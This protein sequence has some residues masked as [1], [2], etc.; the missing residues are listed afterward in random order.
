MKLKATRLEF[1]SEDASGYAFDVTATCDEQRRGWS[2][3]V[4]METDG[5]VSAEGAIEH[6]RHACEAFLRQLDA[7]IEK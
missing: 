7:G 1:R 2:A 6:L 5:M 3:S 4:T